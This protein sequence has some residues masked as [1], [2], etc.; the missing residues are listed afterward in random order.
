MITLEVHNIYKSFDRHIVLNDIS[1][2]VPQGCIY[3][4]LGPNGA[5]KTTF[6]RIINQIITYDSGEIFIFCSPLKRGHLSRIGYLPEERG[7]YNKMKV[8][9]QLIYLAQ[10]KGLFGKKARDRI[11]ELL[12]E[13]EISG[14]WNKKIEQLSKGMQQ[15]L[16]FIV[17]IMNEPELVI[18]DE[19]FTG[20][21]PINIDLIKQKILKMRNEGTTFILSTHRMETVEELCDHIA[22]INKASKILDG[23]VKSIKEKYKQNVFEVRFRKQEINELTSA[24]DIYK[25]I[26]LTAANEKDAY[27]GLFKVRDEKNLNHLITELIE[28][29]EIDSINESIPSINEIFISLVKEN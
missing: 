29:V 11:K 1:I 15:K 3:G 4:L 5:G 26:N 23:N 28:Q 20:F 22:L 25:I 12:E 8:G 14:W 17:S 16:Q 6:I 19:P 2:E 24:T 9:E 27:I 21:D 18:L 13:F 10:L 7:L